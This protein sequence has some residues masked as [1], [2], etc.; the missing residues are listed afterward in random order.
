MTVTPLSHYADVDVMSSL[1]AV[2]S[3]I[4]RRGYWMTPPSFMPRLAH[5]DALCSLCSS[6]RARGNGFAFSYSMA[7]YA[8][9]GVA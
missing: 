8:P 7:E 9:R 6:A 4:H 5:M 2:A 1:T 3:F